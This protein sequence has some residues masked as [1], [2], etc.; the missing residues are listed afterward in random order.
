MNIM[1]LRNRIGPMALII[2]TACG[3]PQEQCIQTATR[4]IRTLDRLIA[5]TE[6]GLARGYGYTTEEV[7]RWQWTHCDD[8]VPRGHP[9][10]APRMCFEPYS[11]TVRRPVAIDP[12]VENRKLSALKERRQALM[13][14]AASAIAACKTKY[15]ES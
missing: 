12:Q 11:D 3:T 2:L 6:A 1:R 8:Y 5:E 4:D 15:P 13:A 14:R 7:V 9:P 10:V